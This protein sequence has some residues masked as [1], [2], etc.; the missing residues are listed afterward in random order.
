MIIFTYFV[1]SRVHPMHNC[2]VN[3]DI[4]VLEGVTEALIG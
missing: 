3:G 1:N 2:C 4:D